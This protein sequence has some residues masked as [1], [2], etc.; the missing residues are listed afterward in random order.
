MIS[1]RNRPAGPVVGWVGGTPGSGPRLVAVPRPGGQLPN[2]R[3]FTMYVMC[4]L[5]KL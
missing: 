2:A 4:P 1:F 3:G 5:S